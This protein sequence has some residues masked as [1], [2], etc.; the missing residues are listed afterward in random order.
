LTNPRFYDETS[1]Y[2]RFGSPDKIPRNKF[3]HTFQNWNAQLKRITDY[4]NIEKFT[5]TM[6]G[7]KFAT[8]GNTWIVTILLKKSTPH[9][10]D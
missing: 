10:Q 4:K 5:R 3:L 9:H 6:S 8:P 1:D 7:L 2:R